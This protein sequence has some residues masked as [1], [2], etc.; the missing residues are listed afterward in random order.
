MVLRPSRHLIYIDVT[1]INGDHGITWMVSTL[2][3][4]SE[5]IRLLR[6][7]TS[8]DNQAPLRAQL[9]VYPLELSSPRAHLYEALSHVW[10]SDRKPH[11]ISISDHDLP[12]TTNFDEA[13][14]C[15][16]D[17]HLERTIWIDAICIN[18]DEN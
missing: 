3:F 2:D 6:I 12:I 14:T 9:F 4:Q 7:F 1:I 10:S 13:L 16:R 15:L 11:T 18:Q 17:L 5:T 8:A